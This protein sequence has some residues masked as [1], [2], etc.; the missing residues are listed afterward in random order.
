[1]SLCCQQDDRREAVRRLKGW[2][3][4]DYVEVGEKQRTLYLYFLGKLP[5]ELHKKTTGVQKHLRILGGQRV[6]NIQITEVDPVVD[7]DPEKDDYLIVRL[8]Q[9]GDFSTYSLQLV[10]VADIDPRYT[11]VDFSFKIDCPSDLD[12]APV[13]ACE[14]PVLPEP[15]INYLAKDYGSF[16]QLILDRLALLVPDW[17]ERHLPDL[18]IALVELLAYTGDYLSYYQDAVATEAY[19]DTARERI[20]VRRHARLVDYTLHEGCNARTWVCVEVLLSTEA[21]TLHASDAAFITEPNDT[22]AARPSVLVWDDL[23]GTRPS[24]YEVFEPIWP[25]RTAPIQLRASHNEIHFYAWGEKECCLEQGSTS[26]TLLDSWVSLDEPS[27]GEEYSTA[28]SKKRTLAL[29][30]GDVL[31]FEEVLGPKTGIPA[32]AD[33]TRRH[34]VRITRLTAG[35]DPVQKTAEGQAT[36]YVEIEWALDDALPF[37]FCLS[38]VSAPPQCRYVENISVARGNAI[39]VD[40]GKTIE[41]ENLGEVSAHHPEVDCECADH[42]GDTQLIA[43]RFRPQLAKAPLTFREPLFWEDPGN[44][45]WPPAASLLNQDVRLALPQVFLISLPTA[46]WAKW[47]DLIAK[48][49][50]DPNFSLELGTNGTAQL[51][52]GKVSLSV[53]T[54]ESRYDLLSSQERDRHFVV[55]LNNEGVAYLRFGDGR[56]GC[57]PAPETVFFAVYRFGNGP[58]GNVGAEAISRLVTSETTKTQLKGLS[59]TIRNP[60]PARGGQEAEPISE[61]KLFAP[62]LFRRRLER[63]IAAADYEALTERNPKIQNASAEL[64][65][66]GSWYEAEV[67]IDPVGREDADETLVA[68]ITDYLQGFRRMGHEVRVVPARYVPLELKIEVSVLP[69]YQR[70]HIKAAL[71]GLFSNRVLPRQKRGF[72]H[73]DNLTFGEGIEVSRIIALAQSVEGV[74]SV[75]VKKF[76]RLFEPPNGELEDGVLAL[77]NSE[78][79]QL[80]NDPNFPEK[81]KLEVRVQGGR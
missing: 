37:P 53:D 49:S 20:S 41:L 40:S 31:I 54:W 58:G 81:G 19:L 34:P 23:P 5:P 62:H 46:A 21:V 39:L 14:P 16:R 79:A 32:D 76:Q 2:N 11:Q 26:A 24:E 61:A 43:D 35:E 25:D 18:G 64:T 68:E 47:S 51:K 9:Y 80:D 42:P 50:D 72:F 27:N 65:W 57:Q 77:R 60:L 3:G 29:H 75:E 59:F 13:C 55:E 71:L 8:N 7:P 36:P 66:T 38:A 33:P 70:A 78:I 12:C 1:M 28:E 45:R 56:L 67:A 69:H 63:A 22:L 44:S 74:Q 52:L 73:P 6:T 30:P 4:L 48:G 10:E 17:Q 15:E